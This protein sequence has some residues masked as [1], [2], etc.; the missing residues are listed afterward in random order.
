ML[1]GLEVQ[2]LVVSTDIVANKMLGHVFFL[3]EISIGVLFCFIE[4]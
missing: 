2:R 1:A 3:N 4:A